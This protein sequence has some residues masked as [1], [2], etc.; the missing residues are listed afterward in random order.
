M[1]ELEWEITQAVSYYNVTALNHDRSRITKELNT[2]RY[3][4][5]RMSVAINHNYTD[6]L[7]NGASVYS[8][9]WSADASYQ[10]NRHYRFSVL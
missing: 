4:D 5:D 6:E 2:V 10:Y 7:R 1:N 3:N 9:Y 8:S